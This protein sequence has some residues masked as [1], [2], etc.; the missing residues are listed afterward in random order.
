M[1]ISNLLIVGSTMVSAFAMRKARDSFESKRAVYF[2][3]DSS[4]G[5]NIVAIAINQ[6]GTLS[7]VKTTSTQGIGGSLVTSTGLPATQDPL[8]SQGSVTIVG[9]KYLFT[10]NAGSNTVVIPP[11]RS[12]NKDEGSSARRQDTWDDLEAEAATMAL[13]RRG[14]GGPGAGMVGD[15][16]VFESPDKHA[17][18]QIS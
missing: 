3:N 9:N 4:A 12:N 6:D 1:H 10:V 14:L 16:G 7:D 5:S 15:L 8:G 2:L 13:R 18:L 17:K 11:P